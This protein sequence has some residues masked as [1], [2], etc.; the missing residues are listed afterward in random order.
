MTTP[1]T[2][3]T[4]EVTTEV[5]LPA[6]EA[7]TPA[8]GSTL[9]L[10]EVARKRAWQ[11]AF[12]GLMLDVGVAIALV[13]AASLPEATDWS[14]VRARAPIMALLITKSSVQAVTAWVIRRYADKSG[15]DPGTLTSTR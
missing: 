10:P 4:T 2:E 6:T 11:T 7:T 15:Y 12:Q 13:I 9:T 1:P 8:T 5:A 14:V 3:A